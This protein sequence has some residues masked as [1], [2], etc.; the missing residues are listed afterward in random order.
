[1]RTR[2]GKKDWRN[3]GPRPPQSATGVGWP[4]GADSGRIAASVNAIDQETSAFAP[5]FVPEFMDQVNWGPERNTPSWHH[6]NTHTEA[7]G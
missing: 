7:L 3:D 1:M 4:I 6:A 5:L 2:I